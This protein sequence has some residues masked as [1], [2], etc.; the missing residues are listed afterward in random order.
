M[1]S[2]ILRYEQTQDIFNFQNIK[3]FGLRNQIIRRKLK[4][5]PTKK[6]HLTMKEDKD[7]REEK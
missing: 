2:N 3:S 7:D 4:I 6:G 5:F 1:T